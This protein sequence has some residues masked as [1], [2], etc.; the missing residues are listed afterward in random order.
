MSTKKPKRK[1]AQRSKKTLHARIIKHRAAIIAKQA[2]R[3]AY[4]F[5][6]R[7]LLHP[8]STFILLCAGVFMAGWT[9]QVIAATLIS[10]TVEAP[11]LQ[12]AATIDAPSDKAVLTSS[13]VDVSGSCPSLSYVVLTL[14]G[15]FNGV[16]WCSG[17][18]TYRITTSLYPGNNTLT[19][20]DYNQTDLQGPP[21]PSIT[22]VYQPP[23]AKATETHGSAGTTAA[24]APADTAA[25]TVAAPL[26]LTSDFHFQTFPSHQTFT[27][28]LDLEGGTPPYTVTI[29]WGDSKTSKLSFP[30]DPVFSIQHRY[31][32]AGY[33]PVVIKS[34][35]NAGQTHVT[36][37]AALI[38][39]SSGKA[40][41]LNTA[42]SNGGTGTAGTATNPG[43]A[44]R[45]ANTTKWLLLAWPFYLVIGLMA[46]SFWL[47]EKREF[48]LVRIHHKR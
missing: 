7:L 45:L 21:T 3:S 32:A 36:Q 25:P 43:G 40:P 35:D 12:A 37:L 26:L 20:Q 17:S 10:A 23:A 33:Y 29:D 47:G 15:A 44:K 31:A 6:K 41:F 16:A 48:A 42:S 14:N 30:G 28:Q 19:I 34:V 4:P 8:L 18:G 9:Y 27:W 38:T 46:L 11:A 24:P 39:D 1:T 13:A 5:H 22:V 2:R